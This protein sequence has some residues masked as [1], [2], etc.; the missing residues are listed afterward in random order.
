MTS[1]HTSPLALDLRPMLDAELSRPSRFRHVALL[2]A[3]MT[4]TIIVT[5]L[6][7]TEPALPARTQVAFGLM[8]VIGLSWAA[9]AVWVLTTRRVLLGRD[10]VVAGRLA[11]TFTTT[12]VAGALAVGYV[13]GGVAPFAA[14]AMGLVLLAV[15]AALL[16]RARHRVTQLTARREVLERELGRGVR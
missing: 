5:S 9:F 15:A 3:S 6:W 2:L 8:T 1:T 12:F 10:G 4:M 16:V 7:L 14:A 11:V 13:N